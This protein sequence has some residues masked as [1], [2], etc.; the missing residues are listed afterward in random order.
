M[1][2]EFYKKYAVYNY[3]MPWFY[4]GYVVIFMSKYTSMLHIH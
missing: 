3:G 2:Y 4:V 1:K